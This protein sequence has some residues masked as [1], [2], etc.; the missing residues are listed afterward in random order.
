MDKSILIFLILV[1]AVLAALVVALI[2]SYRTTRH[3]LDDNVRMWDLLRKELPDKELENER[4]EALGR[5]DM[6]DV[7][8]KKLMQWIDGRMNQ[9]ELFRQSE[10]SLKSA[11]QELGL[12]Q[13]RTMEVLKNNGYASFGAYLTE[14]RILWACRMLKE[15]P[16]HTIE[17]IASDAGFKARKTFQ[18]LFKEQMGLTPSQYRS[19]AKQNTNNKSFN[20]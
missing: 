9:E 10:L 16:N 7:D 14:K 19:T 13:K 6:S 11:A 3:L 12:T 17:S 8:D 20:S 2:L 18:T 4:K 15:K 1:F 5:T